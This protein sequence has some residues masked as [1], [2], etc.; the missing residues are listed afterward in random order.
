MTKKGFAD[1]LNL[2]PVTVYTWK[3]LPPYAKAYL[4][5]LDKYISL[6]EEAEKYWEKIYDKY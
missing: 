3:E 2:A 1:R 6:K 5:L 4:D